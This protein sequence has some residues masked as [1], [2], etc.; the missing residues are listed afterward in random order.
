[1]LVQS[2]AKNWRTRDLRVLVDVLTLVQMHLQNLPQSWYRKCCGQ[3]PGD[4]LRFPGR[5]KETALLLVIPLHIRYRVR[6][7]N[8]LVNV[9][10]LQGLTA[11]DSLRWC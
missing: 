1:M 10:N 8:H 6:L 11:V 2:D 7:W 3:S 4:H 5:S 9:I